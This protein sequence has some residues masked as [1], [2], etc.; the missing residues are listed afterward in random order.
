[1]ISVLDANLN[2]PCFMLLIFHWII[3]A[4]FP[5]EELVEFY[6]VKAVMYMSYHDMIAMLSVFVVL[7][8]AD[9]NNSFVF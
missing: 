5:L 1:M 9:S 8:K 7:L 3:N 4:S 2:Y 6:F